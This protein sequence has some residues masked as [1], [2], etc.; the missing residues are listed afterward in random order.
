MKEKTNFRETRKPKPMVLNKD[1]SKNV[2]IEEIG[3]PA[4]LQQMASAFWKQTRND[5]HLPN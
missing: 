3:S 2:A 4:P 1:K 5:W